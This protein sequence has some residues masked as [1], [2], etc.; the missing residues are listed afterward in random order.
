MVHPLLD[1][2]VKFELHMCNCSTFN[3]EIIRNK[4]QLIEHLFFQLG[5]V[6]QR[7]L[8]TCIQIS[9]LSTGRIGMRGCA[10]SDHWQGTG[11]SALTSIV[12]WVV[13]SVRCC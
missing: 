2:K 4:Y 10:D 11:K 6:E 7:I 1:S 5:R 13:L 3:T 9:L 8:V 12:L